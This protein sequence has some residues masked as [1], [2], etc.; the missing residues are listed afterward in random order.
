MPASVYIQT[1]NPLARYLPA[2]PIRRG[3][4]Y[5]LMA[6]FLFAIMAA[7]AKHFSGTY[8]V[9]QI[10]FFRFFFAL[11]PLMPL[12]AMQGGFS[13]FKTTR[14]KGHAVRAIVG[15]A[16]LVFY[17]MSISML[18]LAEAVTLSFTN[19][20]FIALLSMPLLKEKVGIHRWSAICIGFVGVILIA[21]P[22]GVTFNTGV[23]F[24]L[25][26]ALF[27]AFAMFSLRSLGSSEKVLTTTTY[28]TVLSTLILAIP[29]ALTW[30]AP[31]SFFDFMLFALSGICA[32]IGQLF[33]T[34]AYQLASPST[35][36]PFNYT[37]ILW[38]ILIGI[39]FWG[40]VPPL[41]ALLGAS[42]IVS[43]GLYIAYREA[44]KRGAPVVPPTPA[45][46]PAP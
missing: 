24:G 37:T 30:I 8:S 38:A 9:Y 46:P 43:S 25:G 15:L 12:I 1:M 4:V 6:M 36:S 22:H 44:K 40:D 45:S 11:L 29:A 32:G 7:V 23:L 27:Y 13:V 20:F 3:I 34:K 26:S 10:A 42:I 5:A 19:P 18:P 41:T 17:F 31:K 16:S 33:L 21:N 35:I 2:N 14:L 28:F 39:V